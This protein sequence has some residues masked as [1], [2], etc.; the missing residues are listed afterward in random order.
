[1]DSTK[2]HPMHAIEV[3]QAHE[4]ADHHEKHAHHVSIANWAMMVFSIYVAIISACVAVA[5]QDWGDSGTLP[6]IAI[7]EESGLTAKA[8]LSPTSWLSTLGFARYICCIVAIT[9]IATGI[10]LEATIGGYMVSHFSKEGGEMLWHVAQMLFSLLLMVAIMGKSAFALPFVVLG[11][12]KFGFPETIGYLLKARKTPWSQPVSFISH[13]LNGL[14][15]LLHHSA[16]AYFVAA[17][18]TGLTELVRVALAGTVVLVI[19][20]WFVPVKYYSHAMYSSIQLVLEIYFQ[21]E[22]IAALPHM[23]PKNGVDTT[24]RACTLVM[25]TAHWMYVMAAFLDIFVINLCGAE[26]HVDETG[27]SFDELREDLME[28]ESDED[29]MAGDEKPSKFNGNDDTQA[30]F[31]AANESTPL[32]SGAAAMHSSIKVA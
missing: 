24:L 15:L 31:N 32:S 2:K 22:L 14:G 29:L 25:L 23:E 16:G 10:G 4:W 21:F 17:I 7:L 11:L 27:E 18:V 19:Q 26:P 6:S 5:F 30:K 28:S 8:E 9:C 12:W 20:H 3:P 13:M 1:M